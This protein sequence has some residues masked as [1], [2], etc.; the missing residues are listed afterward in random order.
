MKKKIFFL[1][2]AGLIL[3]PP[4]VVLAADTQIEADCKS[5]DFIIQKNTGIYWVSPSTG[6][7][8]Y[9]DQGN[10][11][12][13]YRKTTTNGT[14]WSTDTEILNLD[15]NSIATWA[16]WQTPGLSGTKIHF[17]TMSYAAI[18]E[19]YYHYFDVYDDSYSSTVLVE[20]LTDVAATP[21]QRFHMTSITKTRGSTL[22]YAYR[23]Y[24]DGVTDDY[25][26]ETSI[27]D[28]N[29]WITKSSPWETAYDYIRLYPGNLSDPDD[30]LAV[31]WDIDATELSLKTYDSSGN[32]WSEDSIS[33]NMTPDIDKYLNFDADLRHYDGNIILAAW[34]EFNSATAVLKAWDIEDGDNITA[35]TDI[36]SKGSG[37][38]CFQT[39]VF[40]DQTNNTIYVSYL[41]GTIETSVGVYYQYSNDG[42]ITWSGEISYSDGVGDFRYVQTA[43]MKESLG[44]NYIPIWFDND[45]TNQRLW[46][47]LTNSIVISA[48][49]FS[50]PAI[51]SDYIIDCPTC[52]DNLTSSGNF[53]SNETFSGG[54]PGFAIIDDAAEDSGAPPIWLWG[55]VGMF[56][57]MVPG[58]FI[59]YME[60]KF[61]A[62]NGNLILRMALALIVLGLLVTWGR[63]DWWMIIL[64]LMVAIAPAL[65]SR[66]YDWGGAGGVS[67]HG[68]IGFCATSWIGLTIINRILEGQFLTSSESSWWCSIQLFNEFKVFDL[69]TLPVLNFQFFTVGIPSLLRWDY[70]FFGGNAEIIQY[71]LY[72]I[73]AV[74]AFILFC[75]MVGL[76]FNAFRAR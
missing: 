64:Y 27:D 75:I 3:I 70:S 43:A 6:Y 23:A 55:W 45:A 49:E 50:D 7:V 72:T 10:N 13:V 51:A 47:G 38:G 60:R 66:Q 17:G 57:I 2:I 37:S 21:D 48:N 59:T 74:V 1:I 40:I 56:S 26:F 4:I 73:T 30:L 58:F 54:P 31:F 65:M 25:G 5:L 14:S 71:L 36:V 41:K 69:F 32:S 68:W 44:A 16:D 39:D 46:T 18:D 33:D 8:F 52:T 62:G 9:M 76:L 20:S 61:G 63:F 22:A 12:L 67:Q 15:H 24:N 42:G 53:T 29:T 28:G 35:L 19:L 11:G 34:S